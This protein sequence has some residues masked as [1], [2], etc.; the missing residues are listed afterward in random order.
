M[1][2]D[3]LIQFMQKLIQDD[4][5]TTP[6]EEGSGSPVR[7]S[8]TDDVD[9]ALSR[10]AEIDSRLSRNSAAENADRMVSEAQRRAHSGNAARNAQ[11]RI[12]QM[13]EHIRKE[14]SFKTYG[15]KKPQK[16]SAKRVASKDIRDSF[17]F[18]LLMAPPK[19]M[20]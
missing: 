14:H 17:R 10:I 1:K 8:R 20:E 15:V 7:A 9:S 6:T 11:A 12:S 16:S 18:S 4:S 13:D 2:N 3:P 5:S 19:G